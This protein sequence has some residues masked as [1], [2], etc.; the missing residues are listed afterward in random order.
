MPWGRLW[1]YTYHS[2]FLINTKIQLL[3]KAVIKVV[4]KI[5]LKWVWNNID[6]N[7]YLLSYPKKTLQNKIEQCLICK[8]YSISKLWNHRIIN[9]AF[10]RILFLLEREDLPWVW[11]AC[12]LSSFSI[13]NPRVRVSKGGWLFMQGRPNPPALLV[14]FSCPHFPWSLFLTCDCFMHGQKC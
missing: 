13:L 7:L 2:F 12:I 11:G 6:E 4:S 14:H 3:L 5:K 8:S 10:F 1:P 9:A